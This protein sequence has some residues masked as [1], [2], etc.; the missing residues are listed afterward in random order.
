M[1]L[2]LIVLALALL[3]VVPPPGVRA[4]YPGV[5]G[6]IAFQADSGSGNQI[7]TV[8]PNGHDL[9]QVTH[10]NG[11]AKAPDWS[12]DGR[13]IVFE[14]DQDTADICADV[15]IMNADGSEIVDLVQPQGDP[16][17]LELQAA[18]DRLGPTVFRCGG[19]RQPRLGRSSFTVRIVGGIPPRQ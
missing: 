10:V 14:H 7:Y 1:K 17:L 2:S 6:R 13:H 12:P 11:E 19:R 16:R 4:T 5:N 15:A 8:R 9:R 3:C 18:V